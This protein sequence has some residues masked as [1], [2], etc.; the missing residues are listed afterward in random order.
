M[1]TDVGNLGALIT[2]PWKDDTDKVVKNG[3]SDDGRG[4]YMRLAHNADDASDRRMSAANDCWFQVGA[5][6]LCVSRGGFG[7]EPRSHA[8]LLCKACLKETN[9]C[10]VDI[11][12]VAILSCRWSSFT[13]ALDPWKILFTTEIKNR[14]IFFSI[15]ALKK[16]ADSK[17]GFCPSY[18]RTH[19][20]M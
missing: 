15:T 13:F 3:N 10:S 20:Q 7:T 9:A 2:V 17:C 14:P 16:N 6:G 12:G 4:L 11:Q 8:V 5:Y 1:A 19:F 18:D